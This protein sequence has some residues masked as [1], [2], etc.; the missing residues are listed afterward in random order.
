MAEELSLEVYSQLWRDAAHFDATRG[1]AA[2]WI[3]TVTRSRAIDRLRTPHRER[4]TE[5]IDPV[6]RIGDEAPRLEEAAGRHERQR[7]LQ[8]APRR[9]SEEQRSAIL[10]AHF[11]GL[12][13]ARSTVSSP[14][15]ALP[16]SPWRNR[17]AAGG[18]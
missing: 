16:I 14:S 6:T 4:Q 9:L 7:L 10:L 13:H 15:V 17:R 1:S 2:A 3:A 8:G 18:E 11:E 12:S 5:P